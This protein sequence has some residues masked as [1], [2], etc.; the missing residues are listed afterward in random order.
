MPPC[1]HAAY[2]RARRRHAT[3]AAACRRLEAAT[4][5]LFCLAAGFSHD[6]D[7]AI[8]LLLHEEALPASKAR[9]D[10][11]LRHHVA[12]SENAACYERRLF[13]MLATRSAQDAFCRAATAP[14]TRPPDAVAVIFAA[15]RCFDICFIAALATRYTR[16]VMRRMLKRCCVSRRHAEDT[17]GC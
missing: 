7:T 13:F 8:A 16:R 9:V 17:A 15:T 4:A 3:R 5:A 2:C 6:A 14:L 11:T 12:A 10:V 1:R